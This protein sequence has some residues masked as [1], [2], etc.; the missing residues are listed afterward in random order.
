M[1]FLFFSIILIG[2]QPEAMSKPVY[3][4]LRTPI[5]LFTIALVIRAAVIVLWRFDGLYGQDPFAFFGQALALTERLPQG[6]PPP[7]DFVWP[8]GFPLTVAL[9]MFVL[10]KTALAGQIV[11]LLSGALLP[12]LAYLLSR[13]L[14]PAGGHRAGLLA[15][16]IIA[17][18]GQPILSSVVVMSDMPSLLWATLAAWLVVRLS[19]RP[20]QARWYLLAGAVFG[21]AVFSRW[22]Y[23][24]MAP[25]LSLYVVAVLRRDRG[26]WWLPG[27]S[28]LSGAAILGPQL[29]LS[30]QKP[31]GLF[32]H[33]WLTGWR[34][35]NFFERQFDTLDGHYL[36]RF[37]V[38]VFYAQPAGHPAY[39]FPIL[40]LAS[41]WGLWRL[42][43]TKNWGALIL[44]VGWLAPAYLFLAG[45]PYEN[46][47]YGLLHYMP[48]VLLTGYGLSDIWERWPALSAR[49]AETSRGPVSAIARALRSQVW[50]QAIFALSLLGM[51]AWA[52]PMVRNF[53]TLVNDSKALARQVEQH[54]PEDATLLTFGLTL[55]LQ[56]YTQVNT[57]EIYYLDD[58]S[59]DELTRS[60][61]SLYLLLDPQNIE[62]QWQGKIPSLNYHWL[63]EHTSLTEIDT[64]PPFVL[65]EVKP[66]SDR[67]GLYDGFS[68]G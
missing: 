29:W 23:A 9:A 51:L 3:Q 50:L 4:R 25:A 10:G 35:L 54:L 59:L 46:F 31:E 13:D 17:V 7:T 21:L 5:I 36:Y 26:R 19:R 24:L 57:L 58:T 65:F 56:H 41:F 44:L 39:I 32:G 1:A 66:V 43:Q 48:L 16:L 64:F 42:W 33:H 60:Q 15:G 38:G 2:T 47:R 28:V 27:L 52:Y 37:P 61:P 8:N 55:T 6:Q 20:D 34:P 18:A 63:Q 67:I 62:T 49:L 68:L 40:G 14:F 11:P 45:I 12:P 30:L 22:L 53:V